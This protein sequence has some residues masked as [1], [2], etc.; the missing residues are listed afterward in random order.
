ML[1]YTGHGTTAIT[2]PSS[3]TKALSCF[4][5]AFP[6]RTSGQSMGTFKTV[7]FVSFYNNNNNHHHHQYLGKW[8]H[9]AGG[10]VG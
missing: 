3:F 5:P 4:Q 7:N 9:A 1:D 2:L 8:G 10:A 6:R